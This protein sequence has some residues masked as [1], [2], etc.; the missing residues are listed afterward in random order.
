M[1]GNA[2]SRPARWRIVTLVTVHLL[3]AVHVMH[4]LLAGRSLSSIQ[5]SDAGRFASEGVAT[6]SVFLFAFL[7]LVTL[8][9][10]RVFCAWACH[11]LALQEACRWI[12]GKL[13]IRPR[14]MPSRVLWLV[15]FGAAFYV[16]L[17]PVIERLWLGV[18][19]PTPQLALTTNQLWANLPG[20]FEAVAAVLVG[21]AVM[22]YLLGSLSFC[23]YV[24]PYGALFAVADGVA[25]GRIRLTGDC[26]ACARCTAACTTGVRV[27]EEVLRLGMVANSGCMRCFE[28]VSACPHDALAYRLGV[29]ALAAGRRGGLTRYAFSWT[30]EAVLGGLFGLSF[31]ALHGVYNAVPILLALAASVVIACMGVL[32]KRIMT[33]RGSLQ[34]RGLALVRDGAWSPAGM[35]VVAVTIAALILVGH[36]ALVQY[37][38]WRADSALRQL[39]F[40]RARVAYSEGETAEA[41]DAVAHLDFCSR[42]GLVD[43]ADWAMKQAWLFRSIAPERVETALRRVIALDPAQ[44]VAH[45]N[46]GKELARQGRDAEAAA[47]F[48]EAVRLTPSLA[49]FVPV[50]LGPDTVVMARK[51]DG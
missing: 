4:W 27:H 20:P 13:G 51:Q 28:C 31:V 44:A 18:P 29:P 32:V 25:L 3:I 16:F 14:L 50:R 22:V 36:S 33:A 15:P 5:L 17:F 11:M 12:L 1:A 10:G 45:F 37:H 19:F 9:F 6:A 38:E 40:P 7:L 26:D 41:R 47:A 46:L 30:E 48:R 21:G 39:G 42:F 23:K 49:Q 43:T 2:L 35:L 8:L 34:L 24:C